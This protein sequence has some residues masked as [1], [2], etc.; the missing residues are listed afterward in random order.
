MK[1]IWIKINKNFNE[2]AKADSKYYRKMTAVTRL[3]TVQLLREMFSKLNGGRNELVK[4]KSASSRKQDIV[5]LES[6]R[7]KK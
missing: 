1:R 6:L 7:K 4:N 5:D 2:A 3:E